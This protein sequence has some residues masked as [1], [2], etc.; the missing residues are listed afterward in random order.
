MIKIINEPTTAALAY[1]IRKKED[2]KKFEEADDDNFS[3][4]NQKEKEEEDF[5]EKKFS[6]LI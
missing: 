6:F 4:F 2:L 1:G 3:L 5:T